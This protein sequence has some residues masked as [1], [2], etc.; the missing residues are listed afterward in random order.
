[1]TLYM[2]GSE[3]SSMVST[4]CVLWSPTHW[5]PAEPPE[6]STTCLCHLSH[7]TYPMEVLWGLKKLQAWTY[8]CTRIPFIFK[9]PWG[10]LNKTE[11]KGQWVGTKRQ[12][13]LS[14]FIWHAVHGP[15]VSYQA[16]LLFKL[17]PENWEGNIALSPFQRG[18]KKTIR[19][20]L[21]WH[22]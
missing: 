22:F 6:Q 3:D 9:W 4:G 18:E 14:W 2:V 21:L 15:Q 1:M 13:K 8:M 5:M 12:G 11:T 17:S 7:G 20:S 19:I 10:I 16:L